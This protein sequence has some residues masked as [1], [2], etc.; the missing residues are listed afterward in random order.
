[1]V[2]V[3]EVVVLMDGQMALR[4]ALVVRRGAKVERETLEWDT[5]LVFH[6]EGVT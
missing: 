1:M 2:E 3:G 5:V 6:A 4:V